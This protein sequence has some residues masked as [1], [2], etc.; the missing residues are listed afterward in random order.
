MARS[1]LISFAITLLSV[2]MFVGCSNN[3]GA[4]KEQL[5]PCLPEEFM[6]SHSPQEVWQAAAN[7]VTTRLNGKVLVIDPNGGI[8]SWIESLKSDPDKRRKRRRKQN[9][10]ERPQEIEVLDVGD[11]GKAITTV[12]IGPGIEGALMRV[13]RVFYGK[14]T[15]PTMVHSRGDFAEHFHKLVA[16]ELNG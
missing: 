11:G 15:Q 4:A 12:Y 7:V 6:F 14:F 10:V 8:V 9:V 1:K 3:L 5:Q 16:K 2:A 13:R